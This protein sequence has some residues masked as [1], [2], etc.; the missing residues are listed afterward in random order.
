MAVEEQIV[1]SIEMPLGRA[2]AVNRADISAIAACDGRVTQQ[3][4]AVGAMPDTINVIGVRRIDLSAFGFAIWHKHGGILVAGDDSNRRVLRAREVHADITYVAD[5]TIVE[6]V[7]LIAGFVGI[8]AGLGAISIPD[9]FGLRRRIAGTLENLSAL[10]V[11]LS[12]LHP[13]SIRIAIVDSAGISFIEILS[14]LEH[15]QTDLL[16]VA[17]ARSAARVFAR[18]G[19]HGKQNRRENGDNGDHDEKLDQGECRIFAVGVRRHNGRGGEMFHCKMCSRGEKVEIGENLPSKN[20][21][22]SRRCWWWRGR[23]AF[24]QARRQTQRLVVNWSA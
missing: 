21:K 3:A 17:L 16:E 24:D 1:G 13:A 2:V 18:A 22:R 7:R 4:G 5:Q 19:E 15:T 14:V 23:V 9:S 20:R 6:I 12:Q 10:E 8:V 11:G